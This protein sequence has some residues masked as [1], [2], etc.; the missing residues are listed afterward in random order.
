M[1]L[2]T[3]VSE[4]LS[5]MLFEKLSKQQRQIDTMGKK[6]KK[7]TQPPKEKEVTASKENPPP[8]ENSKWKKN[9]QNGQNGQNGKGKGGKA[10]AKVTIKYEPGQIQAAAY[11]ALSSVAETDEERRQAF[12]VACSMAED[13]EITHDPYGIHLDESDSTTEGSAEEVSGE[14]SEDSE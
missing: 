9:G 2:R 13:A 14:A 3:P 10:D 7:N 1:N 5:R 4:E 8:K 6:F 11:E 12:D